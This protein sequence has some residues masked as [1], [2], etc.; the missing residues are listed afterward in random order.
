MKNYET[1]QD[2]LDEIKKK[3]VKYD[4][5]FDAIPETLKNTRIEEVD[6][7]PSENLSYQI[8]WIQLLLSWETAE[9]KGLHVTTPTP[10]YKWNNLGGLYQSFYDKYGNL[11]LTMQ[12]KLLQDSLNELYTL[13]ESFSDDELFLPNQRSWATTKAMWPVWKWIHINTVAPFTN[14]R[15]KIRKWKKSVLIEKTLDN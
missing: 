2:L 14:F 10:D 5:E 11:P 9:Q 1:K 7:T 4:S 8:G 6:R 3:H 15:T 13:I 12:R